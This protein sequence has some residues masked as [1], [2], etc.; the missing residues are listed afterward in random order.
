MNSIGYAFVCNNGLIDISSVSAQP[1]TA[2]VNAIVSLSQGHTMPM[3]SW[4][5]W[6]IDAAFAEL[7]RGKGAIKRVN[8]S[9]AESQ[10]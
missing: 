3:A 7:A 9:I 4:E 8:I 1:S 5:D 2:K 6:L 10:D